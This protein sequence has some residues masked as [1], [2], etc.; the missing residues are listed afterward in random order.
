MK[1][2]YIG[3]S[4][5]SYKS[6]EKEFYP[7][8]IPSSRHFKYYST[9][10]STVEIN[11]TF[12]RLPSLKTIK[13]WRDK[14][15]LGF[16]YA[17]KGSRFITHIKRLVNLGG[18]LNRFFKRIQPFQERVGVILWQLPPSLHKDVPRLKKFLKRLPSSFRH[19]V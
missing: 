3:T 14:A 7:S 10:F 15:P 17:V 11:A 5:W 18:G 2:V 19:A 8:G 9:Q 16:V 12:Y 1:K 13:A 6:W 4:G